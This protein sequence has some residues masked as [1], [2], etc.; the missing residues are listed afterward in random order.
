M[1]ES[2]VSTLWDRRE[3]REEDYKGGEE[4]RKGQRTHHFIF[5]CCVVLWCASPS[6]FSSGWLGQRNVAI[7]GCVLW[8]RSAPFLLLSPCI[9]TFSSL[10]CLPCFSD[11]DWWTCGFVGPN[12]GVLFGFLYT[13]KHYILA[14]MCIG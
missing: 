1:G 2:G 12:W 14:F 8:C 4:R 6:L 13:Y 5:L 10:F 11:C 7:C 9:A 3:R